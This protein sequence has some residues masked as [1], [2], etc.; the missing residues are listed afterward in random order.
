M[1]APELGQ[2]ASD[3]AWAEHD[4]PRHWA[5]RLYRISA[6]LHHANPDEQVHGMLGGEHGYGQD[7]ANDEFTMFPYYWG[8][9][10]CGQDQREADWYE[11]HAHHRSCYQTELQRRGID[12]YVPERDGEVEALCAEYGLTY[13]HGSD[14]HC[15][16]GHK[17]QW[18][19]FVETHS[20]DRT[21]SVV[22]PNFEHYE[23]GLQVHWY[24][25]IGRSM[26]ANRVVD[27]DTW[28]TIVDA[29]LLSV[30]HGGSRYG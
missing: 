4:T 17:S 12:G 15:T 11:T 1:D 23:T 18:Q 21:C 16:C 28:R 22:R 19:T 7:F 10:R 30:S 24:K 14:V 25:Y 8:D 27:D 26:T 6:A 2:L 20:H 5:D 13:P 3:N 9:C 29:C